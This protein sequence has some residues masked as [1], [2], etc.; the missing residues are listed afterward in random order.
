MAPSFH[1]QFS[2]PSGDQPFSYQ[3]RS[4]TLFC[5]HNIPQLGKIHIQTLLSRCD[6]RQ[7]SES[8]SATAGNSTHP[9]SLTSRSQSSLPSQLRFLSL[10]Y[11]LAYLPSRTLTC[12]PSM[13]ALP[14]FDLN[15]QGFVNYTTLTKPIR[16][17]NLDCSR[18]KLANLPFGIGA[19]Y[20]GDLH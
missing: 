17:R 11:E 16:D 12:T 20:L 15:N 10:S 5:P 8:A 2:S 13:K 7:R 4:I 9:P 14:R 18:A 3:R 1:Q 19:E 6:A